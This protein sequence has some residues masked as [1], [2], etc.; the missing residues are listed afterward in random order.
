MSTNASIQVK[1]LMPA[2]TQVASGNLGT[3]HL[4]QDIEE[5]LLANDHTDV[6]HTDVQRRLQDG[7]R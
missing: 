4:L 1:N 7:R 2:S 3:R 5:R 6:K